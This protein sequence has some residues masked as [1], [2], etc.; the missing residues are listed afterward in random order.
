MTS[1]IAF[2]HSRVYL[3]RP[4]ARKDSHILREQMQIMRRSRPNRRVTVTS[5]PAA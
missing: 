1:E 5:Q 4:G 3:S 2:A